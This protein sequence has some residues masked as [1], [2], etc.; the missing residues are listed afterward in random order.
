MYRKVS[1]EQAKKQGS[2]GGQG[3]GPAPGAEAESPGDDSGKPDDVVDAEFEEVKD[4]DKGK[5]KK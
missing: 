3:Y 4:D 5:K 2:A 1:E